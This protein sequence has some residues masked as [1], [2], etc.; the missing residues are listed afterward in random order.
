[1]GAS[2][3]TGEHHEGTAK[4][5]RCRL[6][7]PVGLLRGVG[8][9]EG[10]GIGDLPSR[11]Q[12]V[13]HLVFEPV[14]EPGAVVHGFRPFPV[15]DP[16]IPEGFLPLGHEGLDD[17]GDLKGAER[18]LE[19]S[20]LDTLHRIG[21]QGAPAAPGGIE[22]DGPVQELF[23]LG[24]LHQAIHVGDQAGG[25]PVPPEENQPSPVVG[26]VEVV[27]GGGPHLAE[28]G[29]GRFGPASPVQLGAVHE[30]EDVGVSGPICT[31]HRERQLLPPE[32]GREQ[33]R[34]ERHG[35]SQFPAEPHHAGVPDVRHGRRFVLR[36]RH[37]VHGSDPFTKRRGFGREVHTLHHIRYEIRGSVLAVIGLD[38]D[39]S[40]GR[41]RGRFPDPCREPRLVGQGQTARDQVDRKMP[42]LAGVAQAEESV[43]QRFLR[44]R[45]HHLVPEGLHG[46]QR[47]KPQRRILRGRKRRSICGPGE[48]GVE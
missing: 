32:L 38:P 2:I 42:V 26:E 31:L 18:G 21:A 28:A 22:E 30:G 19:G 6:E 47:L 29:V 46:L 41:G 39:R 1:M 11:R 4:V 12:I 25:E 7:D 9:L 3:W 27:G 13:Q 15:V 5:D 14:H 20:R 8:R 48:Y 44:V 10:D 45:V 35:L 34:V 37:P 36:D 43:K 24:E 16:A 33:R 23:L 17:V 40:P